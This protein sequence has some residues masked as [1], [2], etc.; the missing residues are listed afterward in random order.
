M[1]R[2]ALIDHVEFHTFE[3]EHDIIIIKYDDSKSDKDDERL[4]ERKKYANN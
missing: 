3:L 4:S 2:S 1:S